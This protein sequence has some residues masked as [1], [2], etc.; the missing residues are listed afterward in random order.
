MKK[1]ILISLILFVLILFIVELV[2]RV[3]Y[4]FC[5]TVLMQKSNKYE[6]IAQPNQNRFRFQNH[7][8]YNS[9]SMRSSELDSSAIKILCF[10]D[11]V[12]NGGVMTD[13]DSL[14]TEILS[15]KVSNM[16]N[17]KV[18]FLNI[19]AGSW[20]PDNC[21]AY[22]KEKGLLNAR[23]IFLVIS[24]HDAYDNMKFEDIIDVHPSFPS[25]QYDIAIY[26]LWDRYL[27]PRI[28]KLYKNKEKSN[29]RPLGI[30]KRSGEDN[31]NSGLLNFVTFAHQKN[32]PL[33]VYLHAEKEEFEQKRYNEQGQTIIKF[34]QDNE[35]KIVK[36]LEHDLNY[37][38]Y[39]DNIHISEKGQKT[40]ADNILKLYKKMN[41]PYE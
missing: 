21:F 22:L 27:F 23:A 16:L 29:Q 7:I 25:E 35:I 28:Q 41:I 15:R 40:M 4:G 30:S 11:S 26:E 36:D 32:I 33:A 39:R 9:L 6:Y 37:S 3:R 17:K 5:D 13:Q 8:S 18:Q 2:L 38:D 34:F 31:L 12:L 14:A 1:K 24:S 20:G 19:S 10:G